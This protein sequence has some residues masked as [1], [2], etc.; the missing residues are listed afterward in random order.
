MY[1]HWFC[2]VTLNIQGPVCK[3]LRSHGTRT[4]FSV[5]CLDLEV[6]FLFQA[7]DGIRDRDVTGV[8]TC[9][10]PIFVLTPLSYWGKPPETFPV[11]RDVWA[12]YK[13]KQDPLA[14]WRTINRAMT[15]NP[16]PESETALLQ[17]GRAS[18][19][20]RVWFLAAGML[21]KQKQRRQR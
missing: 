7:E 16:P 12:P 10:L 14:S 9:A 8:Q 19:R 4:N 20:A 3:K 6:L 17:I 5:D 11:S 13:A 1:H 18:C 21:W 2:Y 15:E